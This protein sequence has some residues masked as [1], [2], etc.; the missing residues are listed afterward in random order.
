MKKRNN[1]RLDKMLESIDCASEFK[2]VKP[3]NDDDMK[4]MA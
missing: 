1:K 4:K 2:H 3:V